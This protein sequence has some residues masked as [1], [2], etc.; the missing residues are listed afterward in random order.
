MEGDVI[1][2]VM[3]EHLTIEHRVYWY[4]LLF[5]SIIVGLMFYVFA[6]IILIFTGDGSEFNWANLS[7][8][9]GFSLAA[10]QYWIRWRVGEYLPERWA[11]SFKDPSL[12][13]TKGDRRDSYS[14]DKATSI[15]F[16]RTKI[17][18][19]EHV[20]K[21]KGGSF[22]TYYVYNGVTCILGMPETP[23]LKV[24]EVGEKRDASDEVYERGLPFAAALAR[25]LGLPLTFED[26]A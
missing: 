25:A 2:Y 6:K 7:G 1:S 16:Q 9:I 10:A 20:Q 12:T 22:E 15:L 23:R 3:N 24:A 17:E 18:H 26:Q 13:F 21:G 19:Q 14:L 5:L 8:L 4:S 11:F